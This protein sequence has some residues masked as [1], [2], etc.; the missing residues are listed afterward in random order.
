MYSI[1]LT[2]YKYLSL[3]HLSDKFVDIGFSVTEVATLYVVPEFPCSPST[4]GV[5]E[6]EWP[7]EVGSLKHLLIMKQKKIH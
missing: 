5:R 4:R 2:T 1:P 6:L 7:E 3:V